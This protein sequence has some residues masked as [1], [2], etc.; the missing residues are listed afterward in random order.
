MRQVIED[1]LRRAGVR[2]RDLDV[3]LELGLQESVAAP[4]ARATASRSSRARRSSP[5][6]R[7]ARSRP[8]AS[9]GSTRRAR[10]RSCAAPA[11]RRRGSRSAF[12][13]F[14]RERLPR[15]GRPLRRRL[16]RRAAGRRAEL[17]VERPLLV[18][19]PRGAALASGSPSRRLRR[20]PPH[21]PVETVEE[22]ATR[23]SRRTRTGSSRSAAAARSTPA[24]RDARA[25][26][27]GRPSHHRR[28]D[29]LRRAPSG[30]PSSACATR[31]SAGSAAADERRD[32]RRDRL[33][34]G[35]HARPAAR[36]DRRHGAER[37]RALRRGVLR[38]DAQR[39]RRPA[40]ARRAPRRSRMR[41]RA[42]LA[43]PHSLYA[44]TRLLEGAMRA[45][46]ALGEAGLAL[47]HAI[48]QAIGGRTGLPHGA[49]NAICL[50][51]RAPVQR[52]GRPATRWRARATRW[53]STTPPRGSRSSRGSRGF[54]RLRDLGVA[55][56]ELDE[57]AEPVAA[58]PGAHANPRPAS[59]E[60]IAGLLRSVW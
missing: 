22:A 4:S 26:R 13:D 17:G 10:S 18:D 3:R 11:A 32:L 28:P 47:G 34:P 23:R 2:L 59:A 57:I 12:V 56:Y 55:E 35:A 53:A 39:R 44:R 33:R 5:T 58:R 14:A 42:S 6:S 49:L 43:D 45:A 25:P 60:E 9:K 20:R 40:R 36:R 21:V 24:R 15:D 7:P 16:A 52:A 1:E 31:P 41:C 37:A 19:E 30:R 8:R 27:P 54:A 48:A 46:Q 38:A 50:P 29:D 51:R